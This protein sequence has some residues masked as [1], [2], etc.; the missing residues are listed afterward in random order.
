[1]P[2]TRNEFVGKWIDEMI[3]LL[4]GVWFDAQIA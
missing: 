1:M 4:L 3:G 2:T